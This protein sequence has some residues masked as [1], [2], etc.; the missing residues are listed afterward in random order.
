MFDKLDYNPSSKERWI[1]QILDKL[2][3]KSPIFF[4]RFIQNFSGYKDWRFIC[5][6]DETHMRSSITFV[7]SAGS[8]ID[9]YNG[10]EEFEGNYEFDFFLDLN[11]LVPITCLPS[12]LVSHWPTQG[13]GAH[14]TLANP[15]P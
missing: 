4:Q 9:I 11:F 2:S 5:T 10:E 14:S 1:E 3:S 13:Q 12:R 7:V 6:A 15:N 8:F